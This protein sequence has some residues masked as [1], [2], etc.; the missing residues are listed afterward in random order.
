MRVILFLFTYPLSHIQI[1]LKAL[2]LSIEDLKWI[3][4]LKDFI[5]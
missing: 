5:T 1:A 2:G 3:Y 4:C